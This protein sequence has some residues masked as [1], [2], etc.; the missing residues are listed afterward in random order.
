M[1]GPAFPGIGLALSGRQQRAGGGQPSAGARIDQTAVRPGLGSRPARQRRH[2]LWYR[3]AS[4]S[5]W[6][7]CC[8]SVPATAYSTRP[9]ASNFYTAGETA[10]LPPRIVT[11][12]PTMRAVPTAEP[13]PTPDT[14]ARVNVLVPSEARLFI[15]GVPMTL[16]GSYR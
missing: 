10:V 1:T 4:R 11:L 9:S 12:T 15:Q 5:A 3:S 2:N 14:T 16:T 6:R 13:A 8:G 7:P